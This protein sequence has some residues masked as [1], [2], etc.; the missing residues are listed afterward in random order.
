MEDFTQYEL[1]ISDVGSQMSAFELGYF[2]YHFR[3]LYSALA[4]IYGR[5][6]E[7]FQE[8]KNSVDSEQLD[9]VAEQALFWLREQGGIGIGRHWMRDLPYDLDLDFS[10]LTMN[11]P[12]KFTG[13]ASAAAIL[14]LSLTVA[15]SGGKAQ[16]GKDVVFELPPIAKTI[17]DIRD[18]FGAGQPPRPLPSERPR[19]PKKPKP[20]PPTPTADGTCA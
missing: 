19:P 9:V 3:A 5:N 15:I 14:I 12:L 2:L 16:L 7:L 20:K 17:R 8:L 6:G 10:G 11:S 1:S 4:E 18:A 13:Y